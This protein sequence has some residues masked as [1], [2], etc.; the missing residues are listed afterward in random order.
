MTSAEVYDFWLWA[1]KVNPSIRLA[2]AG[3]LARRLLREKRR[4]LS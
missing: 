4:I 3:A 1:K 2:Q